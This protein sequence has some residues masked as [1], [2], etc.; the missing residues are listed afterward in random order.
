MSDVPVNACA[1]KT[2]KI[3]AFSQGLIGMRVCPALP[4]DAHDRPYAAPTRALCLVHTLL[5]HRLTWLLLPQRGGKRV[6]FVPPEMGFGDRGSQM[7]NIP[8]HA[9][10]IIYA[11]VVAPPKPPGHVE[12]HLE[13]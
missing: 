1:G 5:C 12:E 3:R 11:E 9:D 4:S 10:L 7:D 2:S 8:P 13:L 6:L